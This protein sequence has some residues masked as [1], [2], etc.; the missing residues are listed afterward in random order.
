M[1]QSLTRA[2]FR[3]HTVLLPDVVRLT[4]RSR[5]VWRLYVTQ[6]SQDGVGFRPLKRDETREEADLAA[7]R[8]LEI[9]DGESRSADRGKN[10]CVFDE[11][12]LRTFPAN[13]GEGMLP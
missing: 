1:Q 11:V 13:C 10:K 4:L 2:A 5:A 7:N 8:D 3:Y 9:E 12:F 6:R